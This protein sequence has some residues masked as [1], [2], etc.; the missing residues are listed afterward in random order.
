M[1]ITYKEP[2]SNDY[3]F[4]AFGKNGKVLHNAVNITE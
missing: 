3:S 4:F 2:E 1:N